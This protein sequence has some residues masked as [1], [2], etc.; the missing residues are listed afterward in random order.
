MQYNKQ[1]HECGMGGMM[2]RASSPVIKSR[3]VVSQGEVQGIRLGSEPDVSY[4][5][6]PSK[7]L[8]HEGNKPLREDA[9]AGID[10][11]L[12]QD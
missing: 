3:L 5:Y 8:K 1:E 9:N 11:N 4:S 6:T 12:C 10:D 7:T 2:V